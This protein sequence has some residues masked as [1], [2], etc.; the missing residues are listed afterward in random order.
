MLAKKR[1][2]VASTRDWPHQVSRKNK[3]VLR[4]VDCDAG[5]VVCDGRHW[6]KSRLLIHLEDLRDFLTIVFKV[7]VSPSAAGWSR[8][9][10]CCRSMPWQ[11]KPLR[12]P[13]WKRPVSAE[14]DV[15]IRQADRT[16]L[17]LF[18]IA[19]NTDPAVFTL[20]LVSGDRSADDDELFVLFAE[21]CDTHAHA[22]L[23]DVEQMRPLWSEGYLVA[24]HQRVDHRVVRQTVGVISFYYA[25]F[26]RTWS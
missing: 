23:A 5:Y 3:S 12:W 13:A 26:V 19:E 4:D 10:S 15:R 8:R 16:Y 25:G 24:N 21:L 20:L 6:L 2:W 17:F 14:K 1:V 11:S 7:I 22:D 18:G 9:W